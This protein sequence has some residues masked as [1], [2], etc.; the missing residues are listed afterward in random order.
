ML[1]PLADDAFVHR[2]FTAAS[3]A[4]SIHNTQPWRFRLAGR[5]LIE[6][7][8]D[9]DRMLWIADP[10]G[11]ALH[12][13]CGAALF[14]LRLAIRSSGYRALVW[15]L[16]DPHNSPTLMASVQVAAGGP[17]SLA[18]QELFDAIGYR[19]TSREP[20]SDR[21][22]PE[23]VQVSLE[24]AAGFECTVLRLLTPADTS[25]VLRLAAAA[26]RSLN[27]RPDHQAELLAWVGGQPDAGQGIPVTALGPR[28]DRREGPVR[29]FGSGQPDPAARAFATRTAEFELQPK[30]AVLSTARDGAQDWLRAGQGLERVLLTATRHGLVTSLLYQLLELHDMTGQQGWWPWPEQPQIIIRFGYGPAGQATQRRPV[31][32][33]L[34]AGRS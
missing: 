34:D 4:P 31:P 15:P 11:R 28:P 24:Q 20:F 6:V 9:P 33:V 26:D 19:H 27:A 18:E 10:L 13:S 1:S 12:L 23:P 8:A 16:P 30:L 21:A 2:I 25:F 22:I 17:A 14:N 32:E 5:D 29:D 3:A 7:H